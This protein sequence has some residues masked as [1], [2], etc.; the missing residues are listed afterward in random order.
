MHPVQKVERLMDELHLDGVLLSRRENFSWITSGKY[1]HILNTTEIGVASILLT[2][3][4]KFVITSNIEIGRL[5]DEELDGSEYSPL[6]MP[7]FEGSE[8]TYIHEITGSLRIGSD[9][10]RPGMDN[11]LANLIELRSQLSVEEQERYRSMAREAADAVET[12]CRRIE[13]GWTELAIKAEVA[14]EALIRG[15][16]PCCILIAT[17]DRILKYRHPIATSKRLEHY[18]M[19]VLGGEKY[20]LNASLTRIVSFA[21]LPD[22]IKH[23]HEKLAVIHAKMMAATRPGVKYADFFQEVIRFYEEAG[24]PDEWKLHHQGGLTGYACREL[25]VNPATT[26]EIKLNQAFAWNPTITG[27]KSE[28]TLLLTENGVENMTLTGAWPTKTVAAGNK[29]WEIS[30][31]LCRN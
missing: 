20:G 11:I 14:K 10:P 3:E 29:T 19:V 25:I 15:I 27:T 31:I 21:S 13:P 28:D 8:E 6:V 1:N 17:D 2:R 18:A 9:V 7:W 16:N 30:D 12:V 26:G 24:Y 22:E 5:M 23:K 4:K